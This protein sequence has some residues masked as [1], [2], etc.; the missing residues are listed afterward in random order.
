MEDLLCDLKFYRIINGYFEIQVKDQRYKIVYPNNQQKYEAEQLYVS[1]MQDS[2]FDIEYLNNS[3]LYKI[4]EYN[5]IWSTEQQQSLDDLEENIDK[6]KVVLYKQYF[7][8]D[9]RE[10]TKQ[11][12]STLRK[13]QKDLLSKKHSLDYLTLN[14]FA[15]NIK[16]QY[17]IS[18]CVLTLK[19][20]PVFGKNYYEFDLDLLKIIIAEVDKHRITS[21]DLKKICTGELWKRYL[22]SNNVFGPS[23]HLND[24]QINLLSLQKMYDN[25]RQHP[26]RPEEAIIMDSDALDGWFLDQ[27]EKVKMRKL[28]NEALSK[29]RGKV[30]GHDYIYIMTNGDQDQ[31]KAVEGMNDLRGRSI[32]R[33]MR[34]ATKSGETVSWKDVPYIKQELRSKAYQNQKQGVPVK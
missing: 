19:G 14:F 6:F 22:C 11:E 30:R 15:N 16:N 23:I 31:I 4:L 33:S 10:S 29:V 27:Q 25:V 18:Q 2:R 26:E 24:D 21:S 3:Q 17:L 7:D 8:D 20:E 5:Q 1:L 13:F 34:E 9:R 32:A 28:K 12:L